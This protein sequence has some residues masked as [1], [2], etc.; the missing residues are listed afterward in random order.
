M[1]KLLSVVFALMLPSLAYGQSTTLTGTACP[2]AG[3]A[4]ESVAGAGSVGVQVSGTF[5]GTVSFAVSNDDVTFSALTVYPTGSSTG[6]TS[7]TSAGL[8]TGT[9][10]GYKRLKVYFS[11]FST[12]SAVVTVVRSQARAFPSP[13]SLGQLGSFT[14][15]ANGTATTFKAGGVIATDTKT[16]DTAVQNV[17]QVQSIPIAANL[18]A[19]TGDVLE[20]ELFLLGANNT[21]THEYNA[22]FA[23]ATATCSG[24]GATVCDAGCFVLPGV[25]N[26]VAFNGE[27]LDVVLTQATGSNQN[28][29]RALLGGG[30]FAQGAGGCTVDTTA[31]TKFVFATRNTTTSAASLAQVSTVVKF[32]P[33]P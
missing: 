7:T 21:N 6:V 10:A 19:H 16:S 27:K 28:Y 25:T 2:G 14:G 5:S 20:I 33:V 15:S 23:P 26:T 22:F 17:W 24:T 12:G 11:A 9:V 29:G 32:F 18:L 4:L 13:A 3:C 31:A 1:R 8:W 30:N